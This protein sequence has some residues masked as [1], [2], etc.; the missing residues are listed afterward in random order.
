MELVHP[1]H[2]R[3]TSRNVCP[4]ESRFSVHFLIIQ[5]VFDSES[6]KG[7]HAYSVEGHKVLVC[8][9]ILLLVLVCSI[10]W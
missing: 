7:F 3:I 6:L 9:S 5:V 1:K 8:F 4:G 10:N 2:D